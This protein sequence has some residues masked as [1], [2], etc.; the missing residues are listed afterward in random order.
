MRFEKKK[1]E[2]VYL[3]FIF[4]QKPRMG[5]LH[6]FFCFDKGY[7]SYR[8]TN[9]SSYC[10]A[11]A[12]NGTYKLCIEFWKYPGCPDSE[13]E[14]LQTAIRELY[15]FGVIDDSYNILFSKMEKKTGVG[16]PLPSVANIENLEK[17]KSRILEK[18]IRNVI[19]TGVMSGKNVFYITDVLIDTY[20][21]VTG[22]IVE[23]SGS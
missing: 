15:D 5:K 3:N 19:P 1:T 14:I 20:K 10:P 7:G 21:K 23:Y 11:V 12:E 6:H 13:E 8:I 4:D 17:I 9:C 18:G 2:D 22:D 16:F